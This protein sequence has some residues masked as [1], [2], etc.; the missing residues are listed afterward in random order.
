LIENLQDSKIKQIVLDNG[1]EFTGTIFKNYLQE[2]GIEHVFSPPETPE[3]N[4]YV[5]RANQTILDKA[6]AFL[7]NSKLTNDYWAEAINTSTFVSNLLPTP[8]CSNLSP[9]ELWT[10]RKPPLHRL[11][12]FGCKV[13]SAV[14]KSKRLWKLGKVGEP[15]IL[16]GFENKVLMY[17]IVC[18]SN[19]KLIRT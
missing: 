10:E 3:H 17:R 12:L 4:G 19:H 5:E 16:V 6:C 11:R 1:G 14:P 2:R 13:Y 15:G 18:L 7:L 8:S 9:Y